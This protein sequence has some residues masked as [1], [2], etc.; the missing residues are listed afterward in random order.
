M[1]RFSLRTFFLS[2]LSF[3]RL[4]KADLAD[5]ITFP[6]ELVLLAIES[7]KFRNQRERE[8]EGMTKGIFSVSYRVT[9]RFR[10]VELYFEV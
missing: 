7:L 6:I 10:Q 1:Y 4:S 2:F 8:R 5:I 3:L 9:Q